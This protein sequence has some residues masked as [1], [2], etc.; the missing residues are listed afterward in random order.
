MARAPRENLE[1]QILSGPVVRSG[2][3]KLRPKDHRIVYLDRGASRDTI[4][5]RFMQY[6]L[7][8][9][10]ETLNP[11]NLNKVWAR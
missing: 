1:A 5:P 3:N 10:Q 6:E 7:D 11:P 9:V 8:R 4:D 2:G